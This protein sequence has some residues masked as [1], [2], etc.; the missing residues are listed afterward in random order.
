[1]NLTVC[2][3]VQKAHKGKSRTPKCA[4]NKEHNLPTMVQCKC[5]HP[6]LCTSTQRDLKI[7]ECTL[8]TT[9]VDEASIKL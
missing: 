2:S 7:T 1:M 8:P 9:A 5:T 4:R 3:L 6:S